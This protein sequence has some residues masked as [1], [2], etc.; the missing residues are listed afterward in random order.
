MK[1]SSTFPFL[2][3]FF[4]FFFFFL[5]LFL[6]DL[7]SSSIAQNIP[8]PVAVAAT[9]LTA[10][11]F[12]SAALAAAIVASIVNQKSRKYIKNFH[13]FLSLPLYPLL[14]ALLHPFDRPLAVGRDQSA[15]ATSDRRA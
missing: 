2:L 12:G 5:L 4:F 11:A 15:A 7:R 6:G 1:V 14:A 9:E 3:F 10:G 13:V 8:P